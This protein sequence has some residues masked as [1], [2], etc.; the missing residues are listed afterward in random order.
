MPVAAL[1]S[2][3][4]TMKKILGLLIVLATLAALGVTALATKTGERAPVFALED[5]KGNTVELA[6]LQGKVVFVDFWAHW[7]G[8][9]KKELPVL[10]KLSQRYG[11]KNVVFLAIN[12]DSKKADALAFL[13][14]AGISKLSVLLDPK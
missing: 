6:A 7:C 1:D 10:E 11:S 14:D 3:G 12:V 4:V 2:E 8:P 5:L 13:K 9:C